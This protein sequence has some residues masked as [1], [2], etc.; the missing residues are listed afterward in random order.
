MSTI[1]TY[2]A[3]QVS[4]SEEGRY[5]FDLKF[6]SIIKDDRA[7]GPG[8][9]LISF[10][11][12]PVYF[13]KYQPLNRNNIFD[14]RWLKHI[15]TITLRGKRVGF[16]S[17]S[18]VIKVLPMVCDELKTILSKLLEDK[19]CD[20][21]K[22]TG[23][24][25]SYNRIVFASQNWQQFSAATPENILDDFE[26]HYYKI[27]GIQNDKQAKEV[28]S[29]IEKAVIKEFYLPINY[30]KGHIKPHSIDCIE[31]RVLELTKSLGLEIE[32]ELHLNG[33]SMQCH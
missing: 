28:T 31:S 30:H 27:G 2:D 23:V 25:T 33:R 26:F 5:P 8:V 22:D 4:I 13:G 24:C 32:L 16:G 15:E 7:N 29:N 14:E 6:K 1:N 11:D 10:K 19:L 3:I 18:R 12:I 21:L 20:C 17:K 9:Y